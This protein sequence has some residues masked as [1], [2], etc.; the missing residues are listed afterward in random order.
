M[1]TNWNGLSEEAKEIFADFYIYVK[2]NQKEGGIK[3]ICVSWSEPCEK[4]CRILFPYIKYNI[5]PCKEY[6]KE[7]F[8]VLER[9]LIE[10]GWI[11][12]D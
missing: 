1:K 3:S 8:E 11:G 4:L 9:I 10:D 6:G 2:A 5:C 7:A 12:N